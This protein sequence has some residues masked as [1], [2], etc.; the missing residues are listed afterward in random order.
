MH[1]SRRRSYGAPFWL[2]LFFRSDSNPLAY[3]TPLGETEPRDQ[4]FE[5][6]KTYRW[7]A[8]TLPFALSPLF[9]SSWRLQ[10]PTEF[11]LNHFYRITKL[12]GQKNEHNFRSKIENKIATESGNSRE[13]IKQ[14]CC[15]KNWFYYRVPT[16]M[17]T[18]VSSYIRSLARIVVRK[19]TVA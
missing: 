6:M 15:W 9:R 13:T 7:T 5:S 18:I 8:P 3:N 17:I 1:V 4:W 19:E 2:R 14:T 11:S 10:M 16:L 12:L